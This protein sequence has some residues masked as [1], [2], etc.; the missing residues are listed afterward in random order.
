MENNKPDTVFGVPYAPLDMI[1]PEPA[2]KERE[3]ARLMVSLAEAVGPEP[4]W[5]LRLA[6]LLAEQDADAANGPIEP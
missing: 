3:T 4:V 2:D 6:L 5:V 1:L